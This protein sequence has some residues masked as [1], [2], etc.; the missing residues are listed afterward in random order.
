MMRRLARR[1]FTLSSALSLMLGVAAAA[2]GVRSYV[3]TDDILWTA[4][5]ARRVGLGTARGRVTFCVIEGLAPGEFGV[6]RNGKGF[7]YTNLT[8]YVGVHA[9]VPEVRTTF[10][11][12]GFER[13]EAKYF[14][15]RL[16]WFVAPLWSVL[17]VATPLPTVWLPW[18][19]THRSRRRHGLCVTCGYDLRATPGRCPECGTPGTTPA[20]A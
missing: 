13:K 4:P 3:A 15:A 20:L 12:A 11:A 1:L 8:S 7:R 10:H 16:R 14:T 6:P 18:F 9:F 19:R 2:V 5:G 17:L